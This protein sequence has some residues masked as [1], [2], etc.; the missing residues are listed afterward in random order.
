M[1]KAFIVIAIALTAALAVSG[2]SDMKKITTE[3]TDG[4]SMFVIVEE[5]LTYAIIVDRQTKVTYWEGEGGFLTMLYN[6]DGTPRLWK[7]AIN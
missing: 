3:G 5:G 4:E 1:K 7:G 2:C 6:A